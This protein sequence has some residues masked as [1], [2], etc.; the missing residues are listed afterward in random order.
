[1]SAFF[2]KFINCS[3]CFSDNCIILFN[4]IKPLVCI[5]E[6]FTIQCTIGVNFILVSLINIIKLFV[7][8]KY[9]LHNNLL[10]SL[11]KI[12]IL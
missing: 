8:F 6:L 4:C 3:I 12:N 11:L 5:I 7:S 9:G 10:V 2:P 1:M